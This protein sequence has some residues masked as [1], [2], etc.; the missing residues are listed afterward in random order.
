MTERSKQSW[1]PSARGWWQR[2]CGDGGNAEA[3]ARLRRTRDRVDAFL[4]PEALVLAKTLEPAGKGD[5]ERFGTAL[6]LARVLS[7]V[8]ESADTH[9][10]RQVGW[11]TMPTGS[12]GDE[13]P[14]LGETRFRRLLLATDGEER[15]RAFIRLV[16]L[17]DGKANVGEFAEAFRWWDHPDGHVR[18][19]WA[20]SYYNAAGFAP[21]ERADTPIEEND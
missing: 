10:M 4:I 14:R 1:A 18:R 15:V 8:R 9:P 21:D 16:H 20:F 7:H 12:S 3:R 11:R 19:Q 17:L 6:D 5:D 2:V 13:K